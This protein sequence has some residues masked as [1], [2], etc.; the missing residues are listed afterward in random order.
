MLIIKFL[1]VDCLCVNFCRNVVPVENNK[2]KEERDEEKE[3]KEEQKK[4]EEE[5]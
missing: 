2:G 1:E 5:G 3:G 4:K